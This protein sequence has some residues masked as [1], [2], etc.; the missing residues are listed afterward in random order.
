MNIS[1][2]NKTVHEYEIYFTNLSRYAPQ[3]FTLSEAKAR[4]FELGLHPHI[5]DRVGVFKFPT[6]AEVVNKALMVEKIQDDKTKRLSSKKG[7]SNFEEK[8]KGATQP[9]RQR[10]QL[11]QKPRTLP[12]SKLTD[13]EVI[14][15][16]KFYGAC[17]H[18]SIN[19]PPGQSVCFYYKKSRY[20]KSECPKDP[21]NH[22]KLRLLL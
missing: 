9:K 16:C 11:P 7:G 15:R 14:H 21:S 2:G 18:T 22:P 1:Q 8:S 19:C 3:M 13:V 17:N 12:S 6:Y 10:A 20:I 4:H 5:W